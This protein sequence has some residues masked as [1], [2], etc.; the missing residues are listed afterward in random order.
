MTKYATKAPKGSKRLGVVVQEVMDELCRY[1][2]DGE[3]DLLR[4]TCARV[5]T[6]NLGGRDVGIYMRPYIWV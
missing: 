1:G 5:F 6:K 3:T 4:K 2:K